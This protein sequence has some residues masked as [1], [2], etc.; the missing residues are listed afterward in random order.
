M[1]IE[2]ALAGL[3]V[4]TGPSGVLTAP[5]S[6]IGSPELGERDDPL[7]AQSSLSITRQ[8]LYPQAPAYEDSNPPDWLHGTVQTKRPFMIMYNPDPNGGVTEYDDTATGYA[9]GLGVWNSRF[10][11]DVWT[12]CAVM[13]YRFSLDS[14][15]PTATVFT[16]RLALEQT[17]TIVSPRQTQGDAKKVITT[18][19]FAL[20]ESGRR[21]PQGTHY[22]G[23]DYIAAWRGTEAGGKDKC[24][25]EGGKFVIDTNVR[26]PKDDI[27]RPSTPPGVVTPI[28]VS[29]KLVLEVFFSVYG[30]DHHGRPLKSPGPG[31]LRMLRVSRP[32]MI[33]SCHMIPPIL[34]LP[35]YEDHVHDP[36]VGDNPVEAEEAAREAIAR[37]WCACGQ[38]LEDI[39]ARMSP[40]ESEEEQSPDSRSSSAKF[41]ARR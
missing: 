37:D 18:R 35:S 34:D 8:E 5:T 15:P 6:P 25:P 24:G 17:H 11:S 32:T 39:E 1:A 2:A 28:T 27:A 23:K 21:P 20:H 14:I 10:S 12:V 31:G 41:W 9:P 33:P 4:A 38:K 29:H 30:Q 7:H 40:R 36:L 22:P 13:K 26:L 19:H 3:H 16:V